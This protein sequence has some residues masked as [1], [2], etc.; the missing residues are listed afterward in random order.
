MSVRLVV[1]L[2]FS[3]LRAFSSCGSPAN[4]IEAENC[5]VGNPAAQWD[6]AGPSDPT[7]QGFA[8]DISVNVG[9]TITFKIN[10][11]AASY[12]IN[13]YRMGY[14]AG[15]GARQ[16]AS[17]LPNA[18]QAQPACL[19]DS[20]TGLID[21]GNWAASASWTVPA[22]ATS[23]IYFAK[24]TRTDTGKS[25]HIVFVVRN[26][27]GNSNLLFQ[28]SDTTWQAYNTYG[29]NSLNSGSP[30]GRAYKVSYNRPV[31][32]RDTTPQHFV[33]N[34]EY[35]MVR[36]LESNGY[37]VSY[38][39]GL[40]ADRAGSLI[41]NHKVYLSVGDDEYWSAGQRSAVEAARAAG[42]NL[43]F[44]SGGEAFWKTRWEPSIDGSGAPYR[45]LVSYKETLANAV[46][47]PQDPPTWTGTWRDP[48]FSPPADGGRPE[49]ALSGTLFSVNCCS[50][51]ITVPQ[52]DGQMR[53]W[54]NTTVA[55][56]PAGSTATLA[57]GTLG[58]A[59]DTDSDNGVRPPGLFHLSTTT[60]TISQLL[61]DYGNTFGPGTA[62]H[63]A[64]LYKH[65]SGARVFS[66][67]TAQWSWGL[68]GNHDVSAS[69][70]DPSMQQA[71][72]NLLADMGVQPATL[73]APL[74]PAV[75]STDTGAPTAAIT[76]P[77]AGGSVS[78]T[79]PVTIS[80][81]ASDTGGGV[82]AAVE[83]SVDNGATWHPATGRQNWSYVWTPVATGTVTIQARAIDD[84]GN[85]Q[86]QTGESVPAVTVMIIPPQTCPCSTIG[87]QP[88]SGI[89]FANDGRAIELGVR[90]RSDLAGYITGIRFF[91][92]PSDTGTHTGHLWDN[93][94]NLL[95]TVIFT[96][97]SP[98]GW[99]QA[100]IQPPVAINPGV[101]YV[102]SYF[103]PNGYY[104]FTGQYFT[105]DVPDPPLH[106]LADGVG[107]PNGVFLYTSVPAFPS[108]T[109]QSSNYWVD[110]AFNTTST[111]DTTPPTILANSPASGATNVATS[112]NLTA[113]FSKSM[114]PATINASTFVLRDGTGAVVP[115]AVSYNS[116]AQKATLAPSQLAY[117]TTYSATVYGLTA[118]IQD[119]SGN[120]MA[121]NY[122]WTFTTTAAPPPLPSGGPGG[123]VLVITS[124]Q[125]PFT[126]Y[127]AEIL[128]N[129]G[130]NE[131]ATLDISSVTA[132][133]LN[134]YDVVILGQFPLT[135]SQVSLLSTWVSGGGNLIAM[136]PDKQLAAVLGLSDAG[137]TL[138]NAYLLMNSSSGPG[139]G[140][141][142]QTIQ[143][144]GSADLYT[145]NGASNLAT[146]Y[147]SAS[148]P[149]A[150][151]AV[152]LANFGTGQAAAFTYDLA[153]S[154][155]STRQGNAAWSGTLRDGLTPI[156]SDNLFFGAAAGD[157][158]PDWIDFNKVMIPQADE[159]QRLLA[160]LI[161]QMNFAKKPLPRFWYFPRGLPAVVIMTGDDHGN[162]G[163]LGRFNTYLADSTTG[164][165][166]ADW[167]CIRG[168][169]Y[170]YNAS[171]TQA[172]AAAFQAQGFEIALHV[173]T[174]CADWTPASLNSFYSSQLSS[175]AAAFPGLP[176]PA[177]N[178]T[179]CVAWSDYDTQP[180][181]EL[182]YGIRLD[183]TYY[184]W[185][186]SWIQNRP[187]MFTGSGMPMRFTKLDG[188]LID[189]YQATS[190]LTDESGQT[191][192]L[193]IDTLLGNAVGPTGYYGAFTANMHNDDPVSA[194]AN[195]IVASAQSHGV[196]VVSAL[197]MLQW[198]DGRNASSFGNLSWNSG[199]LSFTVSV[200]T[201]TNG[202]QAMLPMNS[203]S[204]VLTG[205]Q[206]AGNPVTYTQQTIKGV[207]YALF[208]AAA[209]SY[210]ASYVTA[211]TAPVITLQ[212][213]SQTIRSGQSATLTVAATGTAPLSYQ[214]YQ[215]ASGDNTLPI[216]GAIGTSFTTAV[217][218]TTT[219][220]WVRVSNSVSSVNSSAGI[221][222][223]DLPPVIS[224]ISATLNNSTSASVTWTTDKAA[225]STVNYGSSPSSLTLSANTAGTSTA[226]TVTLSGLTPNTTYYYQVTSTDLAGS[227]TVAP[228]S[229][230]SFLMLGA[231][232]DSA[233]SDFAG[234]SGSCSV[235]T[236]GSGGA[237][238]LAPTADAEFTG[239]TLPSGWLSNVWAVPGGF[240]LGGGALTVDGA[241]VASGATY[242]V[243]SSLEFT[244]TFS[245]QPF[246]HVGLAA[247][248]NFDAPWIL[249]STGAPGN[250]I[251]ARISGFQD[252]LI[253]GSWLGAPH[254]YR[255]DWTA[256][257][258]TF[259]IDGT[260]VLTQSAVVTGNLALIASDA[261]PGGGNLSVD[262]MRLSPY[263]ASCSFLSRILDAG[264]AVAWN[265]MSWMAG[266][267]PG[268]SL[269]MSYRTGNTSV[270]DTSWTSLA[271]VSASGAALTG[272]SRYIQYGASLATTDDTRSPAL[273]A[274]TVTYSTALPLSITTQPASLMVNA[275]QTATLTVVAAGTPP[276][277]Y[278]WFSGTSGDTSQ[279]VTGA[280]AST[281]TTPALT[282]TKSYWVQVSN[283]SGST[284]S[285]TATVTLN[286]AVSTTTL[287][288]SPNPSV[289][290]QAVILT[291]S[292]T[293][294]ATGSVTFLDGTTTLGTAALSGGTATF[295]ASQLVVGSHSLT[296]AYSGDASFAAS[297][298]TIV[299][300]VVNL[301]TTQ[302]TLTASPNPS[303]S[304]QSVTLTAAVSPV[305]PGTGTVTG[306]V[307]FQDG[308]TVLGTAT[309]SGGSATLAV[310]T[311][312][313]GSHSIT[314]SYSASG[315]FATSASTAVTQTVNVPSTTT[316]LSSSPNPSVPGQ[317]VTLTATVSPVAPGT[318][319]V[320]GSVTFNDGM[321]VLGTATLSG[322]SASLA[323]ATL[324]V[325]SHSMTA[326]YSASGNFAAST[327]TAITQTVN[328]MAT[329]TTL[330]SSPNP[331]VSG[332]S[333]TLTATV[334]VVAPGTGT[335]TG[336]VTF[337][338]GATVLGTATLSGGSATLPVTALTGGS[339]SLTASYGASGNFAASTSSAVTQ[340]VNAASTAT[341]LS[342][343]PN[344]SLSGQSVTLT[345]TVSVVAPGTG[346]VAGSVTFKD[347]TT[348][349]GTATLSGG[350]AILPVTT[351]TVG[352][353]SL[354]AA[355]A[356]TP[357][358]GASTSAA[359]T[360]T[361]RQASTTTGFTISP[362]TSVSG[363][364][365]TLTA[366][367]SAV[368]PGTGTPTGTVSLLSGSTVLGT[369]TL[370]GGT[371]SA[372]VST[373]PVGSFTVSVS[374]G[375]DTNF[376][377]SSS[378][379]VTA[380][381]NQASTTTTLGT[382]PNP[383]VPGQTVT[384]TATVSVVN[385]GSGAA[386][387]TVTFKDGTTSLA[388]VTL[389]NEVATLAISNLALGAHSLTASYGGSANFG[390]SASAAVT[391][392]VNQSSTTTALTTSP[393]PSVLGQ[394]VTL[395]A[396][397]SPVAPGTGTATGT[398]TFK[399]GT[400]VLGTGTLSNGSAALVVSNL[401]LGAHSLAASYG[402][403]TNFATSTSAVV[404]QTVSVAATITVLS[405]TPN[406]SIVGQSVTLKAT[407]SAVAPG[408]GTPTGTVTFNDGG[409][410]VG[411]ATISGG[412]ASLIT[413]TLATGAHSLTAVYGGATNFGGST[414]SV[415]TQTVT[416]PSTTTVLTVNLNPSIYGQSV[417]LKAVV[418]PVPPGTGTPSGAVT[419]KD[420]STV[421]GTATL[422]G[423]AAIMAISTFTG[424]SHALTA[425]YGG[426][427]SFAG[428][429]S[430]TVTQT[431]HLASTTTGL[432]VSP[433]TSVFGQ[434][435]TLT[436][437]VSSSSTGMTGTV[438]FKDGA[439]V[440]G[441]A[442][443]SAG[444][445]SLTV[446]TLSPTIHLL[447]AVYGGDTN[448]STS[449]SADVLNL[450]S[451]AS[452]TTRVGPSP[453]PSV[454]GQSVTLV[455]TVSPVAPGT[456]TPT[457]SV[458]FR[459]AN[460][461]LGTAT[462][463]G[464]AA[465]L[466]ISSLAVGNHSITALYND[467]N[468]FVAS[469]S[470]S[471]T[472]V[473]NPASTSSVLTASPNPS[474]FGQVVTLR[475]TVSA[476]APGGGTPAGSVVFKDGSTTIGTVSLSNGT[477]SLATSSLSPTSHTI[478]AAYQGS[479]SYS[480]STSTVTQTVR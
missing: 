70:P 93:V 205:I 6:L 195:A 132:S 174:N 20:T 475:T 30:A 215:G 449:S 64:T 424:G 347:G 437:T 391:Q 19:N 297:T 212:P 311:L 282:A 257:A 407:V 409:T 464:G 125:N 159:Q 94:G 325:G 122:S 67:G 230:A 326:S 58:V 331:S 271:P 421:V 304:A 251:Y 336:S 182:S 392:T 176:A 3:A 226:H 319:T 408:T 194:G 289:A 113:T 68:D 380:V 254:L 244:A 211:N 365:V 320:T 288:A 470:A 236:L 467:D 452:T 349:L 441:S 148:T 313:V 146:L 233:L 86:G 406:P 454:F 305:A 220:Y 107:G 340:I 465:T 337:N 261:T 69:T 192:P 80:G 444:V 71:T 167:Q 15:L 54:R 17:V 404:T 433:L 24:L 427:T 87:N 218:S 175:F 316:A 238:I 234:G 296:A 207:Q 334:S 419:F 36:W 338:D 129:E 358:Y 170:I 47:D 142:N 247:D 384:L 269:A 31:T 133:T 450:V 171:L 275:G 109:F 45:T 42:V 14:Y 34:A 479:G 72:V 267:A 216:A 416:P 274:V 173:N 300:Q 73:E 473:V 252:V 101:T 239:A 213:V 154:V 395:T 462:L 197:Q 403:S 477:A 121:S 104:S 50:A 112:L 245:G 124:A 237:V 151:P 96:G 258:I 83:V 52:A 385:P 398:I 372:V 312:T 156:R 290:G 342:S 295:S 263:A 29:G 56:Q 102:A 12:Q 476:V 255:I 78:A 62:F 39:T 153:R 466:T 431:V 379:P 4:P 163:T 259:S 117:S 360:Q 250:S 10:T 193:N 294:G 144:H 362:Q 231:L 410:A 206:L 100:S 393:N 265:S 279:P 348:V 95:A 278:Q 16:V 46:I 394:Q 63:Y 160:N 158:E 81:T 190:Q 108:T 472:Q 119:I 191:F 448:Y 106:L 364:S 425:Q 310:G 377:A 1:L 264:N 286:S 280:T 327:S 150:Y 196:P 359:V 397:V 321:T 185:P 9:G 21:C 140:L 423:G 426:S 299:T 428:S 172:Q 99:Q 480:A 436:A 157:P 388:T 432:N 25:S 199:T 445:A 329:A 201:A 198:L 390:P 435:V 59:W 249:F 8:T 293:T 381:V 210:T 143:F 123:P 178:R 84:S 127:Y 429:T 283:S 235:V 368:A 5:K 131:F 32:T 248:L 61:L 165:S 90:F 309:L 355:F 66:A 468:N 13:I 351:L 136:R 277:T 33:F 315:N 26:D 76:Y 443:V 302:T 333:V 323:V 291:A 434:S 189:V 55:S 301:I 420:G 188:T 350:S 200:G 147:S 204:G 37:D 307:T 400:T 41:L 253:P 405:A 88:T 369:A 97:E 457:G 43:A 343:S 399:D 169:S 11:D 339:H 135:A 474:N 414:S 458:S 344:P 98:S 276:L 341:A 332:Q 273:Q 389:T 366:T 370:T 459:D 412:I 401:A 262:W 478:T 23:G 137:N 44:F 322:G 186:A 453:N 272:S 446:T 353:H 77:R 49:N 438:T 105:Q 103:S 89:T 418:T 415:V 430:S 442:S 91:K 346:T 345:A 53:F 285:V 202:I 375:G 356:A 40:D 161:L 166:V 317:S 118:G 74:V 447:T 214:W 162:G 139:V 152:T 209:G 266:T 455:A 145:L 422:S 378:A 352:S 471:V 38:S 383:S 232:S 284:N 387:G 221:V 270:P 402:G 183:T 187:G 217:L 208:S 149:T 116:I 318:G 111:P 363:Q 241:D 51:P 128:R 298:S 328:A 27:S 308:T 164:C 92:G 439:A 260:V 456:G 460:T 126:G 354:T 179:H 35:A 335:V 324:T 114:N 396:A 374:Y 180:Q 138:S 228:P 373:L 22:N 18:P 306:S 115:G 177:T 367:V 120:A 413:S 181:V 225:T 60:A 243:G 28:T 203:A 376:T 222:T 75:A 461:T 224:A 314:A 463:S 48:R 219:S 110:V 268:T 141:V 79:Y 240:T 287:T 330:S 65:P 2:A 85:L 242:A 246:Q 256:T 469:A 168:T 417:T 155:V 361:V 440:L 223:V 130:F 229:P 382:V 371:A 386:T 411:T 357:S 82:V 281:Y 7:I 292:V 57:T 451:Q 227:T 134:S 184:Y 303:V